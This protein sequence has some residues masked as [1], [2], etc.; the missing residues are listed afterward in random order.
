MRRMISGLVAAIAVMSAVPAMACGGLFDSCAPPCGQGY[1]SPCT[2]SQIPF[3]PPPVV[4]NGYPGCNAGCG[5][6]AY[7]RLPDPELQYGSRERPHQY[8]YVNQGPTYTGPGQFAPVQTY[9][10]AAVIY[11]YHTHRHSRHW[12]N[13]SDHARRTY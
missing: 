9:R 1:A 2:Q 5:W 13:Y 6:A 7:E 12:R 4:R 11:R 10:E 8:Y 3:S